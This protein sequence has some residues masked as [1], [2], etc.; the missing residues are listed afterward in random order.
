MASDIFSNSVR[1]KGIQPFKR[2]ST[3]VGKTGKIEFT[4]KAFIAGRTTIRVG[5]GVCTFCT[6]FSCNTNCFISCT[7]EATFG[8]SYLLRC[9]INVRDSDRRAI[10]LSD[11]KQVSLKSAEISKDVRTAANM[12]I[13]RDVTADDANTIGCRSCATKSVSGE[14]CTTI[15][16]PA[17]I[18]KRE[19]DWR[20]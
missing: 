3:I 20:K 11:I 5:N 15:R 1:I 19:I 16:Y 2:T 4:E 7:R 12:D 8:D 17:K 18:V 6:N 13:L 9:Y 10:I 14:H